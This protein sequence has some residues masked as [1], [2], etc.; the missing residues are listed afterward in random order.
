MSASGIYRLLL[1]VAILPPVLLLGQLTTTTI[2]G[3]LT[4]PSGAVV[5]NAQVTAAEISTGVSSHAQANSEGFY[6]L[7]GLSPGQYRLRVEKPG[8]QTSIQEG[9]LV[10]V[11]RPVTVN[12]AL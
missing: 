8:F 4:D 11:N 2:S 3:T 10:E 12:M 7:S 9:I 6:V 1:V 5:P